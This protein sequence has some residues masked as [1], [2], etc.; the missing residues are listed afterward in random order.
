MSKLDRLVSFKANL[1]KDSDAKPRV[2]A[3]IYKS[4]KTL[5][6]EPKLP[7]AFVVAGG[8]KIVCSP[9]L[10]ALNKKLLNCRLG[11]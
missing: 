7:M 4:R 3:F 10:A 2:L 11:K 9:Y 8:R 1:S 5:A 6:K